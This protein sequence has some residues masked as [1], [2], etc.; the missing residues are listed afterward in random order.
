MATPVYHN[1]IDGKAFST[2]PGAGSHVEMAVTKWDL[3]I[4]GNNQQVSNSKDGRKRIAGVAD[5]SGS[6]TLH[7]DSGNPPQNTST[8]PGLR[9]GTILGLELC[10]DTAGIADTTKTFRLSAIVDE[11][12][13]SSEFEGLEE[14]GISFSLAD[15]A[16]LKYPGDA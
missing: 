7:Y 12:T 11:V 1:G 14:Y 15:G 8:G 2:P 16:S 5:A 10:V 4:T 13:A 9:H 3:R 6:L